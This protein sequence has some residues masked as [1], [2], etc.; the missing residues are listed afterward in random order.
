MLT[1][2]AGRMLVSILFIP[3][4]FRG[5]LFTSYE[6]LQ[7]RFGTSVKTLSALIFLVTRTLA[8]G[9]RLYATALV[10]AVVTGVPVTNSLTKT[11]NGTLAL[12]NLA[13]TYSGPTNINGGYLR[14]TT[15][16]A[17]PQWGTGT[18]NI[19]G[20]FVEAKAASP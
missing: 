19:N 14:A 2:Q 12:T 7:Q 8:D 10:I 9:I 18:I 3:A 15:S 1:A 4:Y 11:G 13:N 16:A 5:D 6:L 20:G 17:Q